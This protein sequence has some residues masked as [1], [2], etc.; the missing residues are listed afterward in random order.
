M[1]TASLWKFPLDLDSNSEEYPHRITFQAMKSR[2]NS[3]TPSP[4]GM[5]APVIENPKIVVADVLTVNPSG[6]VAPV[7]SIPAILN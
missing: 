4:G 3:D 1:T 6:A 7:Q 5:V 2:A